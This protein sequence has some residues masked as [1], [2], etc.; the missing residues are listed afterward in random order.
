MGDCLFFGGV[1]GDGDSVFMYLFITKAHPYHF[2]ASL[3]PEVCFL[4]H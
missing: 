4:N 2:A 3:S 1:G